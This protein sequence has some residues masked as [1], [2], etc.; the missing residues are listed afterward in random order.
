MQLIET[1]LHRRM[2]AKSPG[3]AVPGLVSAPI[4]VS[5][6]IDDLSRAGT[7][8]QLLAL[9]RALDRTRFE[10]SLVLLNGEGEVSRSL[11]PADCPV[12]RLGVTRLVGVKAVSAARRLWSF[13]RITKPDIAQIY[14]NDSSYFGVP[15]AK[16]AGVRRVVRVRNNLGYWQT[17]KHRWLGR[18]V[19]PLVDAYLTNS[20][21]GQDAIRTTERVRAERVAVIENGVDIDLFPTPPV[22]EG[23][24]VRG[25]KQIRIG[26]VANLRAVK[27]IDGLMRA[28]KLV[29]DRSPD[30]VFEVAG[31]GEQRAALE[32]LH[33]E[34]GLGERFIL[35]GATADV[36]A[37]LRSVDVAVLPSHSEGMSN[38]MLE[39]MAAGRAVVATDVGANARLIEH[40]AS[41]L[42]VPPKDESALAADI[43]KLIDDPHRA[44][45]F[46][47][48][49]RQRVERD[50]SRAAMVARFEAF[51]RRLVQ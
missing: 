18:M 22:G 38:A 7:E 10:P 51:Y 3:T 47:R 8:S 6:L 28:A 16:L 24:G 13:W 41:G 20:E 34:L 19:R 2:S 21:L 43:G 11:E 1:E 46:G 49:A 30:V 44:T 40:G 12:L 31:E 39:Y 25:S 17:R 27:N 15:V 35:R 36:P 5:Y 23:L 33:R 29:L 4:R 9:I 48:E 42:I 32:V 37:F 26:C 14:F 45:R 50:H